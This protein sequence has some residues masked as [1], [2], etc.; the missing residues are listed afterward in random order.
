MSGERQR[1]HPRGRRQT[2]LLRVFCDPSR[3]GGELGGTKR[4]GLER[5]DAGWGGV[6]TRPPPI[7]GRRWAPA[8]TRGHAGGGDRPGGP[9]G[10]GQGLGAGAMQWDA[11]REG[12]V[13]L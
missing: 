12:A 3:R 9:S 13:C 4:S 6:G 5:Q 1:S 7:G 10:A 11:A 8:A 2:Y